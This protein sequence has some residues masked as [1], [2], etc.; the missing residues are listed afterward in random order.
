MFAS[1]DIT[2]IVVSVVGT[3]LLHRLN[4]NGIASSILSPLLSIITGGSSSQTANTSQPVATQ[5]ASSHPI[6]DTI[7]GWLSGLFTGG[8]PQGTPTLNAPAVATAITH[9]LASDAD[10]AKLVTL[11]KSTP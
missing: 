4:N 9:A 7:T 10:V 3:M 6:I 8:K 2:S 11:P 5:P 1:L